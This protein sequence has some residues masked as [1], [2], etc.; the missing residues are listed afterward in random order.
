MDTK[1]N[2]AGTDTLSFPVTVELNGR[3]YRCRIVD[4]RGGTSVSGS[5][6]LTV[7]G[8]TT[9]L[10]Q[11]RDVLAYKDREASFTVEAAGEG[12]KYQWQTRLNGVWTNTGLSGAKTPNLRFTAEEELNGR[13]YRCVITDKNGVTVNSNTA[14][15]TI[16]GV[17]SILA[18]PKD[19]AVKEGQEA[20]FSVI[21]AGDGLKYQWQTLLEG[22]WRNSSLSGSNTATLDFAAASAHNGRSYRCRVTDRYGRTAFSNAAKLTVK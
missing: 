16:S 20:R 9:I 1:L 22:E 11:P 15:L 3:E 14:M 17:V 7:S 18:H 12:L 21:A 4:G 6:K 10:V 5:A 13:E 19:A 8:V 2:G